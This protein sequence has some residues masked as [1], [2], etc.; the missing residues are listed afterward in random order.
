MAGHG[1]EPADEEHLS[2]ICNT[3][4]NLVWVKKPFDEMPDV[5]RQVDL[6]AIPTRACEGTSLAALEA[7]A[8]G[9]PLIATSVGGLPNLVVDG[10]NGVFVD[11]HSERLHDAIRTLLARPEYMAELG[12]R[13]RNMAEAAFDLRIWQTRWWQVV[14]EVSRRWL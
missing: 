1:D 10:Y 12:R 3:Y 8:A 11:L 14:S 7:M 9:L 2:Q 4:R 5:Y 6:A 13:G